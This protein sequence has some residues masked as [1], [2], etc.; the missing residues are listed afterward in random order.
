MSKN[1]T[2]VQL[3]FVAHCVANGDIDEKQ[4]CLSADLTMPR[5]KKL[6]A[7]EMPSHQLAVYESHLERA[8][9]RHALAAVKHVAEL[10]TM[11]DDAYIAIR[12]AVQDFQNNAELAFRAAKEILQ[13]GDAPVD[14]PGMG[15]GN[16][17]NTQ[18]NLSMDQKGQDAMG[19]F[20]ESVK[21][22]TTQMGS[23]LPPIGTPS[24]HLSISEAESVSNTSVAREKPENTEGEAE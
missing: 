1:Y 24:P 15:P 9:S 2:D 14:A 17:V 12:H 19:V 7:G 8:R 10:S 18:I 6:L 23:R 22:T 13:M 16:Q 3:S 4:M 5:L 21:Q 11:T 20:I